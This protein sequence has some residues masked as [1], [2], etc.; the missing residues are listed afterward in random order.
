MQ[1]LEIFCEKSFQKSA[2]GRHLS[3]SYNASATCLPEIRLNE[4]NKEIRKIS[5]KHFHSR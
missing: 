4:S 2:Y 5:R 3:S 1:Y